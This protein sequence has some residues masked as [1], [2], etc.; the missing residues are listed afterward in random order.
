[1]AGIRLGSGAKVVWFG[2]LDGARASLVVTIAGSSTAL[3]GTQTGAA[4]VAD[5]ADFPAKGRATGGVR[6]HRFL[7]G[8]DVLLLAWAGPVPMRASG[9]TGKPVE[10][11]VEPGRRDGSGVPIANPIAALGGPVRT[12]GTAGAAAQASSADDGMPPLE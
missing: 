12:E 2:A 9:L 5:Y 10:L 1:M 3:P 8:E 7:K 11:N 6:A 4:K